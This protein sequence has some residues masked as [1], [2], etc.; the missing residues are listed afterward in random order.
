MR[1]WRNAQHHVQCIHRRDQAAFDTGHRCLRL[2]KRA[3][4][5]VQLQLR[6]ESFAMQQRH[7]GQQAFLGGDL[8]LRHLQPCLQ[9]ADA[10]VDVGGLRGHCQ[11][12]GGC[13]GFAGLVVGECGLAPATQAAEQIQLPA[14]AQVGFVGA[15]I[16]VEVGRAV[17]HLAERSLQ[18]LIGAGRVAADV[19]RRQQCGRG[20]GQ[21]GAGLGDTCAGLGQVQVLR[22]RLGDVTAQVR[23]VETGPPGR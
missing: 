20:G 3:L 18:R 6:S 10:D 1:P 21:P 16:A 11:T 12:G 7:H 9:A 2:C 5:L 22:Q 8:A 14:R 19:A 13:T 17:E 4:C 15:G 23:V